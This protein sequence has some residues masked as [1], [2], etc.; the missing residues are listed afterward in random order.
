MP[1]EK[2]NCFL[3]TNLLI[4]AL[5]P[6]EPEK[7]ALIGDLLM[8]MVTSGQLVLSVQILN[9][10]YRV[11]TDRRRIM[12]R[13][14]AR[15]FIASLSVFCVAPSGYLV[16]EQAWRIQE[17]TNFNWWDCLLLGAASLAGVTYFLSEDMQHEQQL[18]GM[19]ILNPFRIDLRERII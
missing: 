12:P 3:D 15:R 6:S 1:N 11:P 4:Y 7:R 14:D 2:A 5:D 18:F 10:C 16:T 9:E 13:T 17:A 8:R 19:T